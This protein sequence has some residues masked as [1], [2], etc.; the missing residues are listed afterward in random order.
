VD[1][2]EGFQGTIQ[3]YPDFDLTVIVLTNLDQANPEGI[4]SGIVGILEPVLTPPHLLPGRLPG[5]A[6]PK[7]IDD[8][9]RDVA[10][11]QGL[12]RRHARIEGADATSTEATI[13][14]IA[15]G[16][17][18][19]DLRR[20]RKGHRPSDVVT[21]HPDRNALL[22]EG[23]GPRGRTRRRH[24]GHGALRC[25]LASGWDRP[26]LLLRFAIRWARAAS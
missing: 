17:S 20:L 24:G 5:A 12:G 18:G 2:G 23:T 21:R 7:A 26:V 9:L 19:V 6:P 8:L 15:E 4:A 3:R 1:L 16:A 11:W 22:R 14:E 10:G 25:R 13:C